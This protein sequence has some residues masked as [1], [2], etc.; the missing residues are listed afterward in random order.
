VG[1]QAVTTSEE[2]QRIVGESSVGEDLS[3]Q[4]L[5]N[6]ETVDLTVQPGDFPT[7]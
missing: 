1:G 4:V 3:M 2:V 7:E 5:R 6:G